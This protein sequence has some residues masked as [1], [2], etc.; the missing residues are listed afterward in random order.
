MEQNR[1]LE[2]NP[3]QNYSME[4]WKDGRPIEQIDEASGAVIREYQSGSACAAALGIPVTEVAA[5]VSGKVETSQGK[6]SA[7]HPAFQEPAAS[8]AAVAE[9]GHV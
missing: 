6:S 3:I 8:S 2:Q 4:A 9:D 1:L 7:T 5:V